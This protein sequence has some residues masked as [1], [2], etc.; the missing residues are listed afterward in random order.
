MRSAA[1]FWDNAAKKYAQSKISDMDAYNK[2][3]ERTKSYLSPGDRVLEIGCGTG[4]TALLLSENVRQITASDISANMIEIG[5][6]KAQ[7]QGIENVRFVQ[8]EI[9]DPVLEGEPYDAVLA[10]SI[11]HLL[12]DTPA[13]MERL[14][15]MLKTDGMFISKTVCLQEDGIS[16]KTYMMKMI[17]PFL[18]LI[19]KAPYVKFMTL[20]ELEETMTSAGF[21]IIETYNH[22]LYQYIVARKIQSA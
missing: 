16:F 4:S 22:A 3:L 10:F 5:T 6:G 11:L 14:N 17:V 1:E 20:N 15:T 8:A 21:E 12:E 9:F 19:G 18:Q 13:V 2:T 7:N